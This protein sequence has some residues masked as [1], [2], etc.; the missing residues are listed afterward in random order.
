MGIRLPAPAGIIN[1][2]QCGFRFRLPRFFGSGT[3]FGHA[4]L[5]GKHASGVSAAARF[6]VAQ[7]PKPFMRGDKA[8][9][10]F[11]AIGIRTRSRAFQHF[12]ENDQKI[13]RDLKI[14]LIAGM[15][16]GDQNLIRKP[17]CVT[18]GHR[19]ATFGTRFPFIKIVVHQE[20][21]TASAFFPNDGAVML[22]KK[23]GL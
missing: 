17:S 12:F 2:L 19:G 23:T 11:S 8:F 7:H 20:S 10:A 6:R 21:P 18:R 3:P 5:P 13:I 4:P 16:E 1:A 22:P 9:N 14:G 15:V